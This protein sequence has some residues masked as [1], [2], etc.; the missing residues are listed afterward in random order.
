MLC[1]QQCVCKE[2]ILC[3]TFWAL[4][5]LG[6]MVVQTTKYIFLI[7]WT[8]PPIYYIS[9]LYGVISVICNTRYTFCI[10]YF[11]FGI[12]CMCESLMII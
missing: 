1:R 4:K 2:C 3:L 10:V 8:T 12:L 9:K 7:K 11:Y 5:H 6:N